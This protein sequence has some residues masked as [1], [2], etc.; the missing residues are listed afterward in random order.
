LQIQG[1]RALHWLLHD[2]N[3]KKISKTLKSKEKQLAFEALVRMQQAQLGGFKTWEK[4]H[5]QRYQRKD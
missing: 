3:S 5:K 2:K 1:R 4:A